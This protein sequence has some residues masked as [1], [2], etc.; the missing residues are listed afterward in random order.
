MNLRERKKLAAWRAIRTAAM[1]LFDEQG[2]EATTIEQIAA[3]ANVSRATFFNYFASKEAVVLDRDPEAHDQWRALLEARPD[4]EPL[5]TSLT[6]VLLDYVESQRDSMPL[7]HRLKAQSPALAQSAHAFGDQLRTDLRTWVLGRVSG[8]DALIA[9]LQL[10]LALAASMTAYQSWQVD[11]DFDVLT[12]RTR[13]CL[14]QAGAGVANPASQ[15][16]VRKLKS[17]VTGAA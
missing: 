4:D 9:T 7:N 17:K 6:A 12:R 5:W 1:R 10:N 16:A 11:E 3:A 13:Q 15:W 14:D 2:Y 8:D